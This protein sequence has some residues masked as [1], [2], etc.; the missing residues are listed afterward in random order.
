MLSDPQFSQFLTVGPMSRWAE[1]LPLLVEVMAGEDKAKL[2]LDEP[3]DLSK[4]RVFYMTEAGKSPAFLSVD[5]SIKQQI[6]RA[7]EYLKNECGSTICEEK[8]TELEDSVEISVSVF[9]SMKDIPNLL[10]DPDNPKV[11]L[12]W[13]SLLLTFGIKNYM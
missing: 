4:L 9:F 3:V 11:S 10:Q 12:F 13:I 2:R 8:F 7:T 1:D 5:K 6:I